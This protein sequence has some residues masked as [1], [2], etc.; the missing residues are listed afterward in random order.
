[1]NNWL[2]ADK[3]MALAIYKAHLEY[4]HVTESQD[5]ANPEFMCPDGGTLDGDLEPEIEQ[6]ILNRAIFKAQASHI[7]ERL[8][9]DCKNPE[10]YLSEI[11]LPGSRKCREC[12]QCM[13][14]FEK[15]LK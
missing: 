13:A 6:K 12:T 4:H 1:M 10:H 9:E 11:I 5:K 2:L 7:F 15:E 8:N 14:E 3:Q